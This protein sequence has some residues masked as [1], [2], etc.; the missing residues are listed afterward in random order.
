EALKH[1]KLTVTSLAF[2]LVGFAVLIP[3][4]VGQAWYDYAAMV[5]AVLPDLMWPYRYLW[6]ERFGK[7]PPRSGPLTRFHQKVQWCERPWGLAVELMVTIT[8]VSYV[9]R[10]L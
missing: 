8:L 4:V 2:E 3:L 9:W 1:K 5:M 10:L 6:F 7:E